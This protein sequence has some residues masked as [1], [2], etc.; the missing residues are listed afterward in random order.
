MGTEGAPLVKFDIGWV[1][2]GTGSDGLPLY[3][4]TVLV[5][6]S[7][8]PELSLPPRV[9]EPSDYINFAEEYRA[10]QLEQAG[11]AAIKGDA[12]YPLVMWPA[13]NAAEVKL[14]SVRGIFTVEQLAAVSGEVPPQVVELVERAKRLI[15][16]Q[17]ESGGYEAR[18]AQLTAERDALMEENTEM[19]TIINAQI[20]TIDSLKPKTAAA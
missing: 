14:L 10:F 15:T 7:R 9:P 2:D 18:I 4:E 20:M 5:T 3:R 19:K 12:G 13:L 16:L 17:K 6:I 1:E 11:R 8:P